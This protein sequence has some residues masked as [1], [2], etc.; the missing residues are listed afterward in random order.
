M[1]LIKTGE[2]S[3]PVA[4]GDHPFIY[5]SD[6]ISDMLICKSPDKLNRLVSSLE[7]N[8][9]LHYISDGDWSMHDLVMLLLQQYKPAELYFTSYAIRELSMRQLVMA[10]QRGEISSIKMLLDYKAKSRTPEVFQLAAMN[11]NQIYLVPIHAKVTVIRSTAGSISI[12]G[13]SNWTSNPRIEAGVVSLD[14]WL[15]E[16]HINWI[17][18]V[19]ANAEIFK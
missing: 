13:S 9:Q 14:K 6:Q 8:K 17:E 10:Q 16:F 4:T 18:K 7:A 3:A 15:A 5:T 11:F 19:M 2:V 12:V 1:A